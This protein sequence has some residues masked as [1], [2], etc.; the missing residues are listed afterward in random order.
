MKTN[1]TMSESE[2]AA[3]NTA[4]TNCYDI[5]S[6]LGIRYDGLHC[7]LYHQFTE[8]DELRASYGASFYVQINEQTL[9]TVAARRGEVYAK[10]ATAKR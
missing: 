4:M 5:A 2:V 6:T 9:E 1:K 7:G 8:L 3:Y 10:F